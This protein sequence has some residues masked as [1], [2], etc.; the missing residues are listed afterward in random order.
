M[1]VNNTSNTEFL[2]FFV[3][4]QLMEA[5]VLSAMHKDVDKLPQLNFFLLS[6]S[7]CFLN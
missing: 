6:L 1:V 7:N 2:K 3:L 5:Q 4:L